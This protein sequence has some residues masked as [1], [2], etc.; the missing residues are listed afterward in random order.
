M[1][2]TARVLCYC[3]Y[4]N[5]TRNVSAHTMLATALP[6]CRKPLCRKDLLAVKTWAATDSCNKGIALCRSGEATPH[7]DSVR[8]VT[9][10]TTANVAVIH[11]SKSSPFV[12]IFT[13]LLLDVGSRNLKIHL[14]LTR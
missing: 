13:K 8:S 3:Y 4:F 11:H 7:R 12:I 1:E 5:C 9:L 2:S 14:H 6:L 10:K